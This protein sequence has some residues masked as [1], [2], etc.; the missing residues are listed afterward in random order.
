MSRSTPSPSDALAQQRLQEALHHF[1]AGDTTRAEAMSKSILRAAPQFEAAHVL[2]ARAQRVQGFNKHAL[3]SCKAGIKVLPKS[4][5]LLIELALI[6]RAAGRTEEAE[7][8]Y[9]L[10]LLHEP[11]NAMAMHNLGNL[12]VEQV[13]M[14]TL[15]LVGNSTSRVEGGRM[16]TPRGYPGAELS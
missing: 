1:Q 16:V 9:R 10:V 3:Q 2:L 8:T 5:P 7:A 15:V 14:L 13:D 4:V 12:P 6:H 11:R